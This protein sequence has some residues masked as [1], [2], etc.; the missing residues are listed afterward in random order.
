MLSIKKSFFWSAVEQIGPQ[1][2]NLVIYIL[3][4]RLLEPGDFGLI[5]MLALFVSL[6]TIFADAGFSSALIQKKNLTVDDET[7]I[8]ALNIAVGC[9][10]SLLLCLVS[11]L[12]ALFY[13]QPVLVSLLRINSLA[14]VISSFALVHSALLSRTMQFQKTALIGT[15]S[16]LV[17]GVTGVAMA[18]LDYGVWSL[19]GAALTAALVRTGLCWKV[20]SW[21]PKGSVC[22]ESIRSMWGYSSNLLGCSLIGVAYGNL[23]LVVIGKFYSPESL[24]GYNNAYTLCMMPVVV[25]GGIVQKVSFSLFSIYQEDK[26]QILERLREFIRGTLLLSVGCLALLA[27]VADPLIPLVLTEKWRPTI[28]LIRILCCAGALYP[29]NLLYLSTIQ[30]QGLSH[31]NLRLEIIKLVQGIIIVALF[32][33][34]GVTALAWSLVLTAL[35]SYFLNV[36][37][38]VRILGYRWSMQAFDILPTFVLCVLSGLTAWWLGT[39]SSAGAF[40]ILLQQIGAFIVLTWVGVYFFRNSFF[41]NVWAHLAWLVG[42]VRQRPAAGNCL[43]P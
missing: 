41:S 9:G 19:V 22:S 21:R 30:A 27:V 8:F 29:V 5:A 42:W 43:L 24:G 32:Y 18:C 33:R 4:A 17:S 28:P 12:V 1:I 2:C 14:F 23:Y 40:G 38:N 6:A 15:V 10:L 25:L 16:S 34:H 3:L 13:N 37:Y 31:L 7:S 36:W 11:P 20:S 35:L 26:Q 39:R